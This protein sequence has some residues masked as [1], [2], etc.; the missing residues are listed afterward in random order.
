[1]MD[2]PKSWN[3]TSLEDYEVQSR[4]FKIVFLRYLENVKNINYPLFLYE[5]VFLFFSNL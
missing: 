1:M 2:I 3:Y 5:E 4:K